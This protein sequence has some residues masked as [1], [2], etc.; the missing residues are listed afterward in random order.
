MK[1]VLAIALLACI[2]AFYSC[3]KFTI[4]DDKMTIRTVGGP[5]Q[6]IEFC[7]DVNVKLL[8]CDA[9]HPAGEVHIKAGENLIDNISCEIQKTDD[10][11]GEDTLY[12]LVIRNE[13]TANFLHSYN[14]SVD[15]TVYYDSLYH[16]IFNSNAR[17]IIT[18]TLKGHNYLTHFTQ[19]TIEWD[20]LAPNLLIEIAG[21]S[22]N[23][24][25]LTNCYKLDTKYFHGTSD[26]S[27][28][29][30]TLIAST[31]ADYDCHGII[32][33]KKLSSNIHYVTSYSTNTIKVKVHH[34]L[35]VNNGN[36]GIVQYLRYRT[37]R[38]LHIWNDSL[39]Q[40]DTVIQQI[41]CP[42]VIRYNGEYIDIWHYNNEE[43]SIPGLVRDDNP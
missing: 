29:G 9:D 14:Y 1:K 36:I 5:F 17:N 7:D 12:K 3:H 31:Y 28:K 8:H 13:N 43:N 11:I 38:E 10:I 26:L 22:G 19:D 20:S 21:G 24:N 41:L 16:L 42:E 25:V 37:T 18:D 23:F 40:M 2:G 33:T 15:M 32:D 34:Q 27:I 35:D 6:V 4:E 39:H 30:K